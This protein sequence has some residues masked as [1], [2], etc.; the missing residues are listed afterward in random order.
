MHQY[1]KTYDEGRLEIL[2]LV[3]SGKGVLLISTKKRILL[4]IQ[5]VAVKTETFFGIE[6]IDN[7]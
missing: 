1:R 2:S 4:N 5:F 7:V 3:T 6:H